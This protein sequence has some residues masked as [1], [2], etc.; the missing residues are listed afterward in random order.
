MFNSKDNSENSFITQISDIPLLEYNQIFVNNLTWIDRG[1]EKSVATFDLVVRDLPENW[2]FYVFD[3][4]Q[5]FVDILLQF[6]FDDRAVQLLKRMNLID[7]KK[8][9]EYYKDLKFSGEVFSMKD[10]TIFF[11]GEPIV[12]ITAPIV[13]ANMLTAFLLNVFNYPIRVL[14]KSL[15]VKFA[16]GPT[17][18]FIGSLARLPGFEQGYYSI[19]DAYLLDS[20]IGNPFLFRKFPELTPPNTITSNINHAFIKS[21]PTERQAFRYFLDVLVE[22]ANFFFVMTDTYEIK[23]GLAIFIEEIKKTPNLDRKKMMMTIDSGDLKQLAHYMRKELDKNG[24]EE[25]RIQAMG[26]LDE[27]NIDDMV[28]SKTPIDCY[29]SATALNNTIDCPVLELVYKMAELRHE[30]GIVEQKA[31]LTI[32]KESYPGRKQVFRVY[33]DGKISRDII[34][35]DGENLG[36]PLLEKIIENGKVVAKIPTIEDTKM[37]L[38]SEVLTLPESFKTI[39]SKG[40]LY[41]INISDKLKILLD[42]VKVKHL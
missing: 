31:K 22:K 20:P 35:L 37:L 10:G 9:E 24:L 29:V 3:G 21:F 13:E 1:I 19:K 42:E 12:R 28:K 23:K 7:S 27:Y 26:G 15:R 17:T 25:I 5:R 4:L 32:G 2:N 30:D 8:S 40:N 41:K 33:E 6:R 16:S 34:G 18:F 39:R 11:P 14:T 36:K 38:K